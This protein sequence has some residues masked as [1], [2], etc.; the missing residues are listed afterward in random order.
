MR[1]KMKLSIPPL[2][3]DFIYDQEGNKKAVILKVEEFDALIEGLEDLYDLIRAYK[4]K[5]DPNQ[6]KFSLES[7]VEEI[8]AN[9]NNKNA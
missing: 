1:L 5:Q 9:H 8:L 6:E 7:V 3:P 4:V 2:H